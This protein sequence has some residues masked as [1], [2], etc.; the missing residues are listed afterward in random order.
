MG[1]VQG[2]TPVTKAVLWGVPLE[3]V[4]K[5]E[6]LT[7]AAEAD[8]QLVVV[9]VRNPIN[10]AKC[11]ATFRDLI[12]LMRD[13]KDRY[14]KQPP[15]KDEDIVSLGLRL[16]DTTMTPAG[17]SQGFACADISHPGPHTHKLHMHHLEGTPPD[18]RAEAGYRIYYGVLPHGG[19]TA[20]QAAGKKRYL[21]KIPLSGDDLPHSKWTR[22]KTETFTYDAEDAGKTAYYCIRYENSK[23]EAGPWGPIFSA[24]IT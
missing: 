12:I 11:N 2:A 19:A 1:G 21:Q 3:A 6:T 5:M 10:T 9:S 22:R 4:G 15:L 7:E 13:I 24:V 23:G 18:P 16:K 8:L 17:I 14:Y 20:E